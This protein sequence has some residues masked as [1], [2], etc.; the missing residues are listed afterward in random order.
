MNI[1]LNFLRIILTLGVVMDHF[2]WM[3]NPQDLRGVDVALWHL[4]TLAVPAFMTMTFF[5]TAK[6][7]IGGDVTWLKKRFLRL[8]EPFVFWAVVCFV[9][10]LL[11]A[12]FDQSYSVT[13]SDLLW[14]LAL[15]HSQKLSLTQFWFHTDLLLLTALLFVAFRLV[16]MKRAYIY[17][18]LAAIAIGFSMQYSTATMKALFAWMPF[19]AKYP[20]GRMFSMLP[21]MGA[22]VLLAAAKDRLD[23]APAGV[24]WAIAM[25]GIWLAAW[26]V[27]L[28]VTPR[29]RSVVGYEGL[30]LAL[31]AWGVMAM[32]YYIPFDRMPKVCSQVVL[33]LSRYC[34]GVYCVHHLLGKI[35]FDHVFHLERTETSFGAITVAP[36][37]FW[38]LLWGLSYFVCWL[39][40]MIPVKFFKRVV[41]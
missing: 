40:S 9:G 41:E 19:E 32:F 34:M 15:G 23:A 10:T 27:Y 36:G 7:F 26:V 29:P 2:W 13:F 25:M 18:P 11:V 4:R 35:L 16:R 8:Y 1:G 28:P 17:L 30:N 20:L 39:I 14:Q 31:I 22:G 21:Y 12:R 38:L 24:R 6:R 37:W 5:F 33:F 3:P